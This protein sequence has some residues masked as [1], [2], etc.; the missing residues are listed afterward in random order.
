LG[1][2]GFFA[3]LASQTPEQINETYQVLSDP[4]ATRAAKWEAL[5]QTGVHIAM[6]GATAMGISPVDFTGS[7]DPDFAF[8]GDESKLGVAREAIR[9]FVDRG[10]VVR[11]EPGPLR[12]FAS[13]FSPKKSVV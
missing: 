4:D 8:K 5:G 12:D 10:A 3:L 9:N 6:M 7:F 13:G 1:K 2:A 11:A